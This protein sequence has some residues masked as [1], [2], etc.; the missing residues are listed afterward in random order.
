[1]LRSSRP[2]SKDTKENFDISYKDRNLRSHPADLS[3]IIQ[4]NSL[5]FPQ[6]SSDLSIFGL[7]W[8]KK[9][10][11]WYWWIHW[12]STILHSVKKCKEKYLYFILLRIVAGREGPGTIY[13]I[14]FSLKLGN[15]LI[16]YNIINIILD[17][18][19]LHWWSSKLISNSQRP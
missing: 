16:L 2:K 8:N 15:Y 5:G 3:G 7:L 10:Y 18:A 1:M 9:I 11:C 6:I 19:E 13:L 4:R 12:S 17:Y 14:I